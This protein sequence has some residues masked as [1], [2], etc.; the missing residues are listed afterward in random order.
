MNDKLKPFDRSYVVST[1]V[2]H[3]LKCIDMSIAKTI[4]RISDFDNDSGKSA[5][6]LQTL[7]DLHML[8]KQIGEINV[9][10]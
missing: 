4:A 8:R 6:V 9:G 3:M 2:K 7:S 10:S 1:T 5:E